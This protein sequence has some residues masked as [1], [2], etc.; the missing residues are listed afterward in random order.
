M[1]LFH[2]SAIKKRSG[3]ESVQLTG[4]PLPVEII[5]W[6]AMTLQLFPQSVASRTMG[7]GDV[8]VCDIIEEMDLVLFQHQGCGDRVDRS[9]PPAL[10]KESAITVERVE[11]VEVGW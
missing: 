1:C 3:G 2:Q 11:E 4:I 10:I 9:I 7:E 8:I 5:V 6:I